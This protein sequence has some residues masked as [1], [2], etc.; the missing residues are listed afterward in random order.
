MK[1]KIVFTII[2]MVLLT[3]IFIN[4]TVYATESSIYEIFTK[5]EEF[6][7]KGTEDS[8]IDFDYVKI[9]DTSNTIANIL[10]A[11]G[12]VIAVFLSLIRMNAI[13]VKK[14]IPSALP[15]LVIILIIVFS[16]GF[17]IFFTN[18]LSGVLCL[19]FLNNIVS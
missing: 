4:N 10:I 17:L 16:L 18:I 2:L 14:I 12:T 8:G 7:K 15:N 19:I 6:M 9:K 13:K 11:I 3:N 5:S 1:Y